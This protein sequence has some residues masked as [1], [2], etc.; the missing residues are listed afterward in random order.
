MK[1]LYLTT[2]LKMTWEERKSKKAII[3][4]VLCVVFMSIAGVMAIRKGVSERK[5]ELAEYQIACTNY[6]KNL[7][8]ME[9][10]LAALQA[11]K[12]TLQ[13]QYDTQKEYCEESIYMKMDG[14]A[15][16]Q[17]DIRYSITTSSNLGYLNS[18]L[19]GYIN[20]TAFRESLAKQF[21]KTDSTYLKEI[22]ICSASNNVLLITVYHYDKELAEQL[23][24]LVDKTLSKYVPTIEKTHGEFTLTLM[25]QSVS[26]K[27]DIAIVNTQNSALNS[28]RTYTSSLAD[29]KNSI[30]KKERDIEFY[31]E[32]N[33]PEEVF[34]FSVM[35][36]IKREAAF[37]VM[38]IIL[39][40]CLLVFRMFLRVMLG[41]TISNSDY[42]ASLNLNVLGDYRE[43]TQEELTAEKIQRQISLYTIR[44][45]AQDIYLND[46]TQDNFSKTFLEQYQGSQE[47]GAVIS[48]A[49]PGESEELVQRN[50]IQSGNILFVIRFGETTYERFEELYNICRQF[51]LKV[52]GVIVAK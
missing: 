8:E 13:T 14:N 26:E 23:L 30:S 44:F 24:E 12:E 1:I 19:M 48:C 16:Y 38:G 39:G 22:I 45:Q 42:F 11:N 10:S 7:T 34:P 9:T 3:I 43:K 5:T 17:G 47:Q 20:G 21:G 46:L 18:A 52:V 37:M 32:E 49:E 51:D 15:F 41:K 27:A 31:K 6:E 25:E 29:A 50:M 33:L 4:V 2:L 40:I 28:L 36:M 35:E